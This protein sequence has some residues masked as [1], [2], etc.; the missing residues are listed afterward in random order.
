MIPMKSSLPL[1]DLSIRG[2]LKLDPK[3][4]CE[5]EGIVCVGRFVDSVL[6]GLGL[7]FLLQCRKFGCGFLLF[8]GTEGSSLS[9]ARMPRPCYRAPGKGQRLLF[10]VSCV[11]S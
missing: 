1:H 8:L 10:K 7:H 2:G 9:L 11:F 5:P 6:G 4:E 3:R